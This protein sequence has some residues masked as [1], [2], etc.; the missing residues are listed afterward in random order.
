MRSPLLLALVAPIALAVGAAVP[1]RAQTPKPPRVTVTGTVVDAS[2]GAPVA[3]AAVT[4]QRSS[5]TVWTDDHGRFTLSKVEPGDDSLAVEELGYKDGKLAIEV[6]PGASP[7]V[8]RLQPDPVLLKGL[9]VVARRLKTRP[10]AMFMSVRAFSERDLAL[11]SGWSVADALRNRGAVIPMPCRW[12][13][14]NCIWSR[15]QV[16]PMRVWLDDMRLF[17]GMDELET[18]PVADLYRV[19]VYERGRYVQV[20]TKT[21]ALRA[22]RYGSVFGPMW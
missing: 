12:G 18:I 19:E 21:W 15:G 5:K 22:A 9:A 14:Q 1:A 8:A 13:G 3:G 4:F 6:A 11:T 2:T 17:G 7:V 10:E 16:L 20:Y